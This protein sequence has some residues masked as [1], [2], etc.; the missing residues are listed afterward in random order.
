[1]RVEDGQQRAGLLSGRLG[2]AAE[3]RHRGG[4]AGPQ[5]LQEGVQGGQAD[6]AGLADGGEL[7]LLVRVE[8]DGLGQL[9]L[10]LGQAFLQVADALA[11]VVA[12]LPEGLALQAVDHP[13]G[14]AVDPLA[15]HAPLPGVAGDVA[16]AAAEDDGGT[17]NPRGGSYD[18]QGVN[19]CGRG[20]E[21]THRV[22]AAVHPLTVHPHLPFRAR[23]EK[24]S[25]ARA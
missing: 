12:L 9:P 6:A 15:G 1:M 4:A 21:H 5:H 19:S 7:G 13:V 24:V 14:L 11:Q 16:V 3:G 10:Q 8:D 20:W 22:I 18:A 23:F 25:G 17:G 2:P